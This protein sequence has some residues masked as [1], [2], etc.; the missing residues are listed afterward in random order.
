MVYLPGDGDAALAVVGV[1]GVVPAQQ[2]VQLLPG[3]RGG[4]AVGRGVAC[5]R[6]RKGTKTHLSMT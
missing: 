4:A 1:A 6:R 2:A 3:G 5:P